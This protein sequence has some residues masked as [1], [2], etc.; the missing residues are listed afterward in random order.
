MK[1]FSYFRS[2]SAWRVR[3][4]LNLKR[5]AHELVPVHLLREGGEQH[6]AEFRR[7]SG[8][9]QVPVL[10]IP[11]P[12]G[13]FYLT[14]SVAIL[15]YLEETYPEPPLLP[16]SS[17][18]RARTR[19]LVQLV[20]SGIQPFQNLG[21]QQEI[22]RR[23]LEPFPFSRAF[24]EPGLAALEHGVAAC[25]GRFA[26]GDAPTLADVFIVPQLYASRR[27]GIAVEAF[28]TLCR[29][30]NACGE[31]PAFESARPEAQPDYEV[32]A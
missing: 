11:G 5:V 10:E 7:V 26:M 24:V 29:I 32:Q 1:L 27:L 8:L 4:A 25:A 6:R 31:L 12:D 28:P 30:E 19:E 23:G 22:K 17:E 14:Q 18:L 9:G 2:S 13:P 15:E 21:T 20:N 16:A 3:I